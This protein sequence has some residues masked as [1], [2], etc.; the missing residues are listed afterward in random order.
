MKSD[1]KEYKFENG[2]TMAMLAEIIKDLNHEACD[3]RKVIKFKRDDLFLSDEHKRRFEKMLT[4]KK[5]Q[6]TISESS[7]YFAALFLLTVN[8]NLWL[9]IRPHVN[10]YMIGFD[11][12][13]P[14]ELSEEQYV[15]Y[16]GAKEVYTRKCLISSSNKEDKRLISDEL[17]RTL[18]VATIM[19]D[20][21]YSMIVIKEETNDGKD[22]I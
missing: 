8:K 10:W 19:R 11:K 5:I 18:A 15:L 1:R 16:L 3:R 22:F 13:H 4:D 17:F 9:K 6:R 7:E 2:N 21:G 14:A 12:Y 20:Y